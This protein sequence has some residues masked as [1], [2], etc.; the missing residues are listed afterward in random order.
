M[1]YNFKIS[2]T[3]LSQ[4]NL[5]YEDVYKWIITYIGI[6]SSPPT[7]RISEDEFTYIN[8]RKKCCLRVKLYSFVEK[9]HAVFFKLRWM[10]YIE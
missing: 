2:N 10:N 6:N 9:E 7:W 4:D 5:I 1:L 3:I 8:F